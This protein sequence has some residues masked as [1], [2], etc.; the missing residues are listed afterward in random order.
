MSTR[1]N[2]IKCRGLATYGNELSL[3]EGSLRQ[4]ENVNIDED[5]VITPRRGFN[6]YGNPTNNLDS[7]NNIVKQML[8][9]KNRIIRHY[10]DKL[11]YEDANGVFQPID[12]SYSEIVENLRIKYQESNSNLYFTTSDGIKKIS[13]SSANDFSSDMVQDAGGLKAGYAFGKVVPTTGGFLPPESKV[14]YRVA[15]GT[16]DANNNLIIGSPSSRFVITNFSQDIGSNEISTV[17]LDAGA[18]ELSPAVAASFTGDAPAGNTVTI[19]ADFAG[20]AGNI[21]LVADGSSSL[22]DIISAWNNDPQNSNNTVTLQSGD[23]ALI[24]TSNITLINGADAIQSVSPGDYFTYTNSTGK[25]VVFFAENDETDE[26]KSSITIGGI[27]IRSIIDVTSVSQTIA[28]LANNMAVIQNATVEVDPSDQT[29]VR[30]TSTESDDIVGLSSNVYLNNSTQSNDN[31]INDQEDGSV[32]KGDFSN[33]EVTSVVP[34]GAT[35]DYFIQVYRTSFFQRIDPLTI[36]DIDPGDEHN[37]IYE[38]PL[39]TEEIQAGEVVFVDTYPESLRAEQVPLYTNEISGEG[40][41]QANEAPPIATDITLFRNSMFY[42]NT[43]SRHSLNLTATSINDF[44]SGITRFVVGNEDI[45]RYYTFVGTNRIQTFDIDN[46]PTEGMF[47]QFN[48]AS[49]ERSYYI[50]FGEATSDPSISG[51][52]GYRISLVD[53]VDQSTIVDRI[54][55]ATASIPDFI[56]EGNVKSSFSG[57]VSGMT[58]NVK[59]EADAAGPS[60]DVTIVADGVTDLATLITN[61]ALNVTVVEGDDTEIPNVDIVLTG[62]IESNKV[63]ITYTNNGYTEGILEYQDYDDTVSYPTG[64]GVLFS[65]S[66]YIARKPTEGLNNSTQDPTNTDF[67]ELVPITVNDPAVGEE[68]TGE[69]AKT[70][71]GGDVLLSETTSLGIDLDV[72]IRSLVKIISQDTESPVNAF[73]T[74]GNSSL[75][76]QFRLEN[77][78]LSDKPFYVAIEGPDTS[79]GESIGDEFSPTIPVS[80]KITNIDVDI[81]STTI[82]TEEDHGLQDGDQVYISFYRTDYDE[83]NPSGP[84]PFSGIFTV[85]T[86][87]VLNDVFT[88]ELI[89]E[90]Q[91]T[92]AN[93]EFTALF[94]PDTV[95]DNQVSPNRLYYSKLSEPEAVPS[96]NFINVGP[97]DEEIKRILSLRDNLFVF[98]N[99]GIYIVSGTSA[100]DFSVRLLDNARLLSSDSA[101]V[102]NN[103]IYCLTEQGVT[104]VTDSGA[105]IISRSIENLIDKVTN[106]QQ[107]F[108][109]KTFGIAYE[110]DRAYLLFCPKSDSDNNATQAF[111]YNI[112]EKTWSQWSYNTTCGLVLERDN[113]LYLGNGDRNYISKERKNFGR[114]DHADRNFTIAVN[115]GGILDNV[116]ELSTLI[117]VDIN[118]VLVQTQDVSI[119]YFN[120]RLLKKID[121]FDN[122]LSYGVAGGTIDYTSSFRVDLTTPYPHRMS[123]GDF[124]QI[125]VEQESNTGDISTYTTFTQV[126][127]VDE[128]TI[129]IQYLSSNN[130]ITNLKFLDYYSRIFSASAG[131]SISSKVE[132]FNF[133]LYNLAFWNATGD[134][135]VFIWDVGNLYSIGTKVSYNGVVYEALTENQGLQPDTNSDD[136]KDI[137]YI[138]NKS[139]SNSNVGEQTRLLVSELNLQES[140]SFLKNYKD[141]TTVVY[142]AYISSKDSLRNQVTTNQT[143]PWIEGDIEVYKHID[144]TIEWNPQHFGDP[145]ALKQIRYMTIM[146]DQ[147]NFYDAVAKFASDASQAVKEVKFTGKGIEYWGDRDF[148]NPDGYWG[149]VGNDIPFRNP[150]P[151]GKQKCRYLSLTFEHSNSREYFRIVGVSAEVRAISGRAYK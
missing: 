88:I 80:S 132:D 22:D 142:E 37:L 139:I 95:S 89:S 57:A 144:K 13:K 44:Q 58:G 51:S 42:A 25:Y 56:I 136:W 26:P 93:P 15:F 27:F 35:E 118:D 81:T 119:N 150:V 115:Q 125:K 55:N 10:I 113:R 111:R 83:D 69:L 68:G 106:E 96:L 104:I 134:D 33:V 143:R 40:I 65:N 129:N 60:G 52:E 91:G 121:K 98:K 94:K 1:A 64:S 149:G 123:D 28:V 78:S 17:K 14:A 30:I 145:S 21:T 71:E 43:K 101:V 54:V 90:S 18:I 31:F 151:R 38:S 107:D 63:K 23:G 87:Q 147:N 19:N 66:K 128:N 110:N 12:G 48:S 116:V 92:A 112:F 146:F 16:K 100:P 45:S 130:T 77:R 5:G 6:D 8:Q 86:D 32:K 29:R 59:V 85:T 41:L 47:L 126:T 39:T 137:T 140:L 105:G 76:G 11:E 2:L 148:S 138:T 74:S 108:A 117:D 34:T 70:P 99:D 120:N 9:Y 4:A 72:T 82:T 20:D 84:S 3:P 131:D 103:Q 79:E 62:G 114:T 67:W 36:N 75:S 46:I 127:V 73:Y 50:Y 97:Q 49:D 61:Q 7:N 102:L 135:T 122:G 24:P 141:P 109:L 133:H 53:V 124:W